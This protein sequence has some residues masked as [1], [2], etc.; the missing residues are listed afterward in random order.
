MN[1]F[2][3]AYKVGRDYQEAIKK[4]STEGFLTSLD[5]EGFLTSLDTATSTEEPS[6]AYDRNVLYSHLK[7]EGIIERLNTLREDFISKSRETVTLE[8]ME[9]LSKNKEKAA[10]TQASTSASTSAAQPQVEVP[11]GSTS[12]SLA[13]EIKKWNTN[14]V[15]EYLQATLPNDLDGDDLA[16]LK[17]QK[18]AGRAFLRLTEDKLTKYGMVEGPASA[19]AGHVE[20]LKANQ[21]E[22]SKIDPIQTFELLVKPRT[23]TTTIVWSANTDE[24]TIGDLKDVITANY[25]EKKEEAENAQIEIFFDKGQQTIM[26]NDNHLRNALKSFARSGIKNFTVA[27]HFSSKPY[28]KWTIKEVL[29]DVLYS[30]IQEYS[31]LPDLDIDKLLADNPITIDNSHKDWF[32][33]TLKII[34][35]AFDGSIQNN[36]AMSRNYI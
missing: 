15:I 11:E 18:I 13:D 24:T 19:I 20:E 10:A 6:Q 28:N 7:Q 31:D 12:S 22:S 8:Q 25:S 35:E 27:F 16:I 3:K 23:T 30:E 14:Q 34:Y 4:D 17:Q 26:A 5:T 9:G 36:E 29:K 33:Q 2:R 21:T 1:V 32:I